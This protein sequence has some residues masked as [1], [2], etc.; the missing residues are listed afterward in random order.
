MITARKFTIWNVAL[1]VVLVILVQ[2]V[3]SWGWISDFDKSAMGTAKDI[4]ASQDIF[5]VMVMLG[6]RGIILTICLPWMAWLSWKRRTWIPIAGFVLVLLFETGLAGA[7]KMAV[8]RSFPYQ[9]KGHILLD[10]NHLAFPSGHAANAVALLGYVAWYV[11][12]GR[13]NMRIVAYGAAVI[14]WC[15]VGVS[16]WLI[17]THWPTDLL[18]GFILGGIL[19]MA[20]LRAKTA[21]LEREQFATQQQLDKLIVEQQQLE[22]V[23]RDLLTLNSGLEQKLLSQQNHYQEQIA[24]LADAKKTLSSE[25][26][27]LANRIFEEKQTK[28]SLQSKEA[29]ERLMEK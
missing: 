8:G 14:V 9:Y 21:L 24:L 28:F 1:F 18:A 3:V 6:L 16:S 23:R 2:Q 15:V 22:E 27:N 4:K 12:Q 5:S 20:I 26:E 25:F 11:T 17:R 10:T 19:A 7:L 29:M 13:R